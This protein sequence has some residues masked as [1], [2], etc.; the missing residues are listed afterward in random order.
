MHRRELTALSPA[1]TRVHISLLLV[2][3]R[4]FCAPSIASRSST[5]VRAPRERDGHASRQDVQDCQSPMGAASVPG[6][7]VNGRYMRYG[8]FV[9]TIDG[10]RTGA[11]HGT[12]LASLA[13][14]PRRHM[15]YL[16]RYCHII[17]TMGHEVPPRIKV[18]LQDLHERGSVTA[19]VLRAANTCF[20]GLDG[21][22]RRRPGA[23]RRPSIARRPTSRVC[24]LCGNQ[25]FTAR[26]ESSRRPPR[27]RRDARSMAWRCGLSPLDSASTAAFSPRE[28]FDID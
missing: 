6:T 12:L 10:R 2:A 4:E 16:R 20:D 14:V 9:L 26:S 22:R 1:R 28:G 15:L 7:S 13:A 25:N 27:H 19:P 18:R 5:C 21:R 3:R 17:C 8:V 24:A 23:R 11:P